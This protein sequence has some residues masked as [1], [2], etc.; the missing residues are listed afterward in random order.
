MAAKPKLSPDEWAKARKH[1]ESDP[2]EG[3]SWLIDEL[4]LPVSGPAVRKTALRDGWTKAPTASQGAHTPTPTHAPATRPAAPPQ[5][6]AGTKTK[7]DAPPAAGM[8]SKVSENHRTKVSETLSETIPVLEDD[9]D[10]FGTLDGVNDM[11]EAFVREYVLDWN[12]TQ[13]ALRAGYSEV[14]AG[15][16]GWQLLQKPSIRE[17]VGRL[18]T[19]KA[20][21][22]GFE[23]PDLIRIWVETLLLDHNEIA[24]YR[25]VCCP[26]CWGRFNTKQYT[27]QGYADASKKHERD[28]ASILRDG[29]KDIGE[30]P[31]HEGDWYDKRKPPNKDCPE[32][33]G[34]GVPEI[35]FADSRNLSQAALMVY[36]GIKQG[37]D[38]LE[39]LGLAKEKAADNL[40]RALGLFKDKEVEVNVNLVPSEDLYKAFDDKMRLARDRQRAVLEE[41]GL[42]ED[43]EARMQGGDGR[44]EAGD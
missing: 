15:Q 19:A 34:D 41:R 31:A 28:R 1:W 27:P 14:S 33:F 20:R 44:P 35:F 37:K 39:I 7:S 18:A 24:Q 9:L 29:G 21:A 13:A 11:Q 10:Q 42:I 3:Y 5:A 12:A 23:A 36:A 17:A 38:G 26:C 43:A 40:A 16:I 4:G 2:R 25:R 6:K 32:C 8:V 22:R 30:F